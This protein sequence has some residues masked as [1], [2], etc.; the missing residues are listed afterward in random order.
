[1][2]NV[3]IYICVYVYINATLI[4]KDMYPMQPDILEQAEKNSTGE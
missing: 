3:Y 4:E 2:Y 1:M